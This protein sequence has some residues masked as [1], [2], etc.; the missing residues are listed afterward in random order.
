MNKKEFKTPNL[1]IKIKKVE[2]L[3]L[4]MIFKKLPHK[5]KK[6]KNLKLINLKIQLANKCK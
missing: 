5:I 2:K 6:I 3:I 1:E 4:K